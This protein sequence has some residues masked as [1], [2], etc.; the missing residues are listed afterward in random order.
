MKGWIGVDLD[1]TLAL[2]SDW[3]GPGHIGAPIPL[4]VERV[5]A[6]LEA[7]EDVRIFT[8]RVSGAA[9]IAAEARIH[10]ENWCEVHLGRVLPVTCEKD[11]ACKQIWDDRAV[12]VEP[13][14]G[15]VL[16]GE[17]PSGLTVDIR[18]QKIYL[19]ANGRTV[20]IVN[21]GRVGPFAHGPMPW[22]LLRKAFLDPAF[23]ALTRSDI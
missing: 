2:Y 21:D 11:Y 23:D 13:N 1:G 6:W 22:E 14:T 5:K 16:S 17:A 4:M 19:S 8:A 18:N 10:I 12:Q 7:G 20:D 15:L 3:R 9:D